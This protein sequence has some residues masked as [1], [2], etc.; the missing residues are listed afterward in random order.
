M[1]DPKLAA[2]LADLFGIPASALRADAELEAELALDSL[3]VVELQL[4]LEDA[5]GVPLRP[6]DGAEVRTVGDLQA[7]VHVALA[8]AR[9]DTARLDD[10]VEGRAS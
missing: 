4:A 10:A 8:G 1:I 3:S 6:Q 5:Y 2:V 7:L 9:A